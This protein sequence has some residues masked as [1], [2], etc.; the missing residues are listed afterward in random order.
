MD[1]E[2]SETPSPFF[3]LLTRCC[4]PSTGRKNKKTKTNG[5]VFPKLD[6]WVEWKLRDCIV[7]QWRLKNHSTN[8][9]VASGRQMLGKMD[10][11]LSIHPFMHTAHMQ[12]IMQALMCS[13]RHI[14]TCTCRMYS[15]ET[16]CTYCTL[17]H[18]HECRN[19]R[20]HGS[21]VENLPLQQ[22]CVMIFRPCPQRKT[23]RLTLA[24][25]TQRHW[26]CTVYAVLYCWAPLLW[27]WQ[28]RP[29]CWLRQGQKKVCKNRHGILQGN[30][31]AASQ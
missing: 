27:Y 30:T 7:E 11:T 12:S 29:D 10:F 5:A 18:M 14:N 23:T 9:T 25:Q 1:N 22:D 31:L 2:L 21:T 15:N 3:S 6:V 24:A 16:I 26:Y 13:S 19:A 28:I 4:K 8:R 20:W 17:L